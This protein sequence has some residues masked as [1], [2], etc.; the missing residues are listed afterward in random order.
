[1]VCTHQQAW[2]TDL[3]S[4]GNRLH[5]KARQQSTWYD[6]MEVPSGADHCLIGNAQLQDRELMLTSLSA[7]R[8]FQ[9]SRESPGMGTATLVRCGLPSVFTYVTD[10]S[11]YAGAGRIT[12][13]LKAPRSPWWPWQEHSMAHQYVRLCICISVCCC[14]PSGLVQVGSQGLC[15][16]D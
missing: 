7:L 11:V 1:M 3:K 8:V 13:A 15:K 6:C 12:F 14:Q 4:L 10:F 5:S 16:L 9:S 2:P